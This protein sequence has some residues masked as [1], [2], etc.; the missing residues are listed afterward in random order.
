MTV[1]EDR[2][3]RQLLVKSQTHRQCHLTALAVANQHDGRTLLGHMHGLHGGDLRSRRLD[4]QVTASA[5]RQLHNLRH[6]IRA[7]AVDHAVRSQLQRFL[8]T[9]LQ[10]IYHIHSGYAHRLKC[11]HRHQTDT[12]CSHNN[13]RL[14]CS[15]SA[16]HGCVESHC[17]RLDQRAFHG[18]HIIRQLEAQIRL[19]R[20]IL[21]KYPVH[22]RC[23]EEDHIR[24][25]VITSRLT[26]LAV[27]AGLA[28]L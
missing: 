2:L 4:R 7:A 25:Q 14:S 5:L 24:A 27:A 21:L 17:Q 26:E 18:T 11:H 6:R 9:L 23:R 16:L 19:V 10:N 20:H 1:T 3:E 13:R 15:G 22:R 8:Q 12:A 28:R